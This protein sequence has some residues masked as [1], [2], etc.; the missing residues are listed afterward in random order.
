V[1]NVDFQQRKMLENNREQ[2]Y[3]FIAIFLDLLLLL[4]L[5][6][7]FRIERYS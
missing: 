4:E 5:Q 6:I 3:T 7:L 1:L 2:R